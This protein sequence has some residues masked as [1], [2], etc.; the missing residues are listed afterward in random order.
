MHIIGKTNIDFIGH[1]FVPY[2][3][4]TL[5]ILAGVFSLIVRGGPNYG[6]DFTG[7]V[8]AQ[9]SSNKS[10][11]INDVR[12]ALETTYPGLELQSAGATAIIIRAKGA[13][14]H[15]D[16]F[17]TNVGELL[18]QK[19]QGTVFT[20]DRTEYVGATVGKHLVKQAF[21][22]IIF[23]FVGIIIYIAFRFRSVIWGS[24][25]VFALMHD[26][27]IVFGMFCLM[28]KE[29]N[30]NIIAA[31]LTLAGYS[32]NDTIVVFDRIRE[33]IRLMPKADLGTVI[34]ESVN[35]TLSR[36][37]IT[38]VTVFLVCLGLYFF[39]GEV[40]HGFSLAMLMGVIIG[41][42]S[43]IFVASPIIYE[44]D[45]Y[46]LRK[47]KERAARRAVSIKKK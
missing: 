40:L 24:A 6:I 27:F 30:L 9:V 25:G 42:Y 29:I 16:T 36:T 15:S 26:V 34:N 2:A 28:N 31:L 32:I 8:L 33:N 37:I 1:R 23:S 38:S 46:K 4:T 10:V 13:Q 45:Q 35:Q 21:L 47:L 5:L 17:G 11:P 44:W 22:A 41:T 7:G 19:I 20:V 18:N 12:A 3:I 39:G 43:S 14:Q